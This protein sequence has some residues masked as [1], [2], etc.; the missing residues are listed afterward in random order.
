MINPL[1][2]YTNKSIQEMKAKRK[3]RDPNRIKRI[4]EKLAEAWLC[5]PDQR[6]GQFLENYIFAHHERGCIFF[7]EDD[8]TEKNLDHYNEMK[9]LE[10]LIW[11]DEYLRGD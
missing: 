7:Q 9:G 6:L 4:C 5:A 11:Q 8:I 10:Y 2:K 1:W 3:L